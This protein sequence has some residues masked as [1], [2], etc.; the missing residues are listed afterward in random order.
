MYQPLCYYL[1]SVAPQKGHPF[2]IQIVYGVPGGILS[3]I[4]AFVLIGFSDEIWAAI[5]AGFAALRTHQSTLLALLLVMA[6][7]AAVYVDIKHWFLMTCLSLL[8]L[9]VLAYC[10]PECLK[11]IRQFQL[12]L[13]T[14]KVKSTSLVFILIG[15][16]GIALLCRVVLKSQFEFRTIATS[17]EGM[18]LGLTLMSGGVWY[19]F[20]NIPV[21]LSQ[22]EKMAKTCIMFGLLLLAKEEITYVDEHNTNL[23]P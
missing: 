21:W 19:L 12:E 8:G 10:L 7:V 1:F 20:R 14:L 4:A 9:I 16:G 22:Q 6:S 2:S 13:R 17:F 18:L 11:I 3:T 5:G 23:E 15:L